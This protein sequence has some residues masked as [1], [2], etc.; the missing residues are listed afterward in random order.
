MMEPEPY[1]TIILFTVDSCECGCGDGKSSWLSCC[2]QF[3]LLILKDADDNP[4]RAAGVD[5]VSR[6]PKTGDGFYWNGWGLLEAECSLKLLQ[7]SMGVKHIV[8]D[9]FL[10]LRVEPDR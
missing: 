9:D 6:C 3:V 10:E 8:A 2:S 7:F 4:W 1:T 5:Y